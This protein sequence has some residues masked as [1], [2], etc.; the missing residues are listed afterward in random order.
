MSALPSISHSSINVFNRDGS[1]I[2]NGLSYGNREIE[3]QFLIHPDDINEYD[4]IVKDVKQAFYTKEVAP[5]YLSNENLYIWAVPVDDIEIT[6]LGA[7]CCQVNVSLIA[8]DPY[9]YSTE[10]S[11][12]NN[13]NERTF[14]VTNTSDLNVYP[15]LNLSTNEDAYF[16]QIDNVSTG[17]SILLGNYPSIEKTT[18]SAKEDALVDECTSLSNWTSSNENIGTGMAKTGTLAIAEGG[19]GIVI[20]DFGSD[21]TSTWHGACYRRS[22]TPCKNFSATFDITMTSTGQNG[23]PYK[24]ADNNTE[25][26]VISGA[27]GTYYEVVSANSVNVRDKASTKNSEKIGSLKK[28]YKLTSFTKVNNS[29]LKFN[30]NGKT[31]YVST[32]YLT[33]KTG[34][35]TI[36][37]KERN[38]MVVKSVN[39]RT[40]PTTMSSSSVKLSIPAGSVVRCYTEKFGTS[41]NYLKLAKKY[42]GYTG[43]VF[44]E[45]YLVPVD[46]VEVSYDSS[47]DLNTA[48][49]KTGI[50]S[51]FGYANDNTKLFE[52]QMYDSSE[53]YEHN[54]PKIT[55]NSKTLITDKNVTPQAEEKVEYSENSVEKEM[56]L[57][58]EYGNW[59]NSRCDFYIER[60]DGKVWASITKIE[61]GVIKKQ[62]TS[63]SSYLDTSNVADK[64]L[65]Y[66]VLYIGTMASDI[67][68]ASDM[69]LNY[70]EITNKDDVVNEE[71]NVPQ[72]P[73]NS[74]I[75]INNSI[76]QVLINNQDSN[77]IVDIGSDFFSLQSGE[78]TIKIS[79]NATVN[80]DVIYNEKYL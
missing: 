65:S 53:W 73:A 12:T 80:C 59:N 71:L 44:E 13:N 18:V 63:G 27:K 19:S 3:L 4:T 46:D 7:Y 79:S 16:V 49:D 39:L 68:K 38:Y 51:I 32:K 10:T 76:P 43:Y 6:E 28:G 22:V 45:D 25:E 60:V 23:N 24:F 74:E 52:C 35:G 61:D 55:Y 17:Q 8:Y 31:G 42:K 64:Q 9:W 72:I 5:L 30:Y 29:W 40:Q 66:I 41:Q 50:I 54:I 11:I 47:Y 14:T 15:T 69:A 26:V 57:S 48:D 33:R 77:S 34:N 78:N 2:Y 70:V 62:M 21:S 37:T 20:G 75:V 56:L 36:T 67:S 1:N 58:G